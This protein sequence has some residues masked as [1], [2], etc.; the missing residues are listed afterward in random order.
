VFTVA[1]NAGSKVNEPLL[2][3]KWSDFGRR[4]VFIARFGTTAKAQNLFVQSKEWCGAGGL[5]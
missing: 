5:F 1:R 4:S 2:S 3:L